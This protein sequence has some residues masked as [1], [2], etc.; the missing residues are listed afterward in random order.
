MGILDVVG[1]PSVALHKE[2]I[3]NTI[4]FT[5]R[6]ADG[7]SKDKQS[8]KNIKTAFR[9]MLNFNLLDE[10]SLHRELVVEFNDVVSRVRKFSKTAEA[11]SSSVNWPA[12]LSFINDAAKDIVKRD[13]TDLDKLDFKQT[14]RYFLHIRFGSHL[15]NWSLN[16]AAK[17]L[18]DEHGLYL[19]T[20][21]VYRWLRSQ[22]KPHGRSAL[23]QIKSLD[24]VLG[25]NGMLLSKV[26]QAYFDDKEHV[27]KDPD[28]VVEIP[29][30][31]AIDISDYVAWRKNG[32]KPKLKGYLSDARSKERTAR[33]KIA[34]LSRLTANTWQQSSSGDYASELRFYS[35]VKL[36]IRFLKAEHPERVASLRLDDFFDH[37]LISGFVGFIKERGIHTSGILFL[38]WIKLESTRN[39]FVSLY[40]RSPYI[41]D[42]GSSLAL[43]EEWLSELEFVRSEVL[44]DLKE[45]YSTKEDLDG[46]RNVEWILEKNAP[47]KV[48]NKISGHLRKNAL[49]SSTPYSDYRSSIL[50]DLL[51]VCPL[52]IGNYCAMLWKGELDSSE[53]RELLNQEVCALFWNK[54]NK[55][56]ELFVHKN[57]LKNRKSKKISSI[58]QPLPSKFNHRVDEYLFFRA[59]VLE[60]NEW[61][62]EHLFTVIKFAN[63]EKVSETWRNKGGVLDLS[64]KP[65]T[66]G[67]QLA[68][69]TKAIIDFYFS[70]EAV[71]SGINPHS[72]RH[73]MASTYLRDNPH[74]YTGLATLLMDDLNT[75]IRVYAK[76]NDRDNHN[77][78]ADWW[79]KN[80]NE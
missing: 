45:L 80:S 64:L 65:A 25:A 61:S 38:E 75:V 5:A 41:S 32:T 68:R 72:M 69:R 3:L 66:L 18:C 19:S 48:I 10:S 36:F 37:E 40:C 51:S 70:E 22:N 54:R 73:L 63:N 79:D 31:L 17:K 53:I 14:L 39:S 55:Q 16:Q 33:A 4:P 78:L 71:E 50:F 46:A 74:D 52:R 23:E 21:N 43:M 77:K 13:A 42:D 34:S 28:D 26:K 20:D 12:Y 6:N 15:S 76:R 35:N 30:S 49:N 11:P 29:E 44:L 1:Q 24:D 60:A 58:R 59:G 57:M 56:Y 67:S 7:S 62:S 27:A 9:Q 47:W 8:V 2:D